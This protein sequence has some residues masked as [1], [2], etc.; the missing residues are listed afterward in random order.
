MD[1]PT[2]ESKCVH[3]KY[4]TYAVGIGFLIL[5]YLFGR[6]EKNED[7][8]SKNWRDFFVKANNIEKAVTSMDKSLTTLIDEKKEESRQKWVKPYQ[9]E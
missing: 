6:V 8:I 5:V 2:S 3:L 4:V 1:C 7:S 9:G